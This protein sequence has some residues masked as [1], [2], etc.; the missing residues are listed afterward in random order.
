MQNVEHKKLYKELQDYKNMY[1]IRQKPLSI[2]ETPK[3]EG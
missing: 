1:N 3:R 2:G